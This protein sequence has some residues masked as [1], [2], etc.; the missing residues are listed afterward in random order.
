[1]GP[2][3]TMR[4]SLKRSRM[5]SAPRWISAGVRRKASTQASITCRARPRDRDIDVV[6]A[7]HAH[8]GRGEREIVG[9][10][11]LIVAQRD[12]R[13]DFHPIG[14][15]IEAGRELRQCVLEAD[16]DDAPRPDQSGALRRARPRLDEG[17]AGREQREKAGDVEHA[18]GAAREIARGSR[19]EAERQRAKKGEIPRREA[20]GELAAARGVALAARTRRLCTPAAITIT[21]TIT[22]TRRR[23]FDRRH[24]PER[25]EAIERARGRRGAQDRHGVEQRGEIG[26]PDRGDIVE[27]A[28]SP[29]RPRQRARACRAR[30]RAR[31]APR[32][33]VDFDLGVSHS[34]TDSREG[35]CARRPPQ[36]AGQAPDVPKGVAATRR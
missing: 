17:E 16:D 12:H 7:Q 27:R 25:D 31:A 33:A 32:R 6:G 29:L 2:N 24:A 14:D 1:M 13:G 36:S 19:R 34:R 30:R 4:A 23:R 10:I 11:G 18:D 21:P 15:R 35:P 5:A 20:A 8:G 9:Q 28:R 3:W 22:P 26:E